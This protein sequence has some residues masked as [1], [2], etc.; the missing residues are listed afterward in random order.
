METHHWLPLITILLLGAFHGVNPGMGWLFAVALGMQERRQG[1]VWRAMIP[2][3]LGHGMAIGAV[4]LI[5]LA[6]G[7]AV[8]AASLKIPVAVTLA[9]LGVHRLVRHSHFTGGGMRVGIRGLTVWSFLMATCHGAGLM[10]LPA[11]LGMTAAVR[12]ASCHAPASASAGASIAVA[13][14]LVHAAGYL[15][16]TAAAAWVVFTRLGVGLLRKTWFNLDLIWAVAL[17]ATGVLTVVV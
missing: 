8:P 9:V 5:A 13:A 4:I 7:V 6:A 11:F 16:V 12:G 2:L 14:T 1:A 3:T 17:I 10:V 15:I